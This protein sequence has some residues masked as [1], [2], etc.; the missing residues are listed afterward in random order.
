MRER[1]CQYNL[2]LIILNGFYEIES[3]SQSHYENNTSVQS[4]FYQRILKFACSR[5]VLQF[6]LITSH[7]ENFHSNACRTSRGKVGKHFSINSYKS[8]LTW[9]FLMPCPLI[10]VSCKEMS[11]FNRNK[12]ILEII[13]RLWNTILS[14]HEFKLE[15]FRIPRTSFIKTAYNYVKTLS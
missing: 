10:F 8:K 13:E 9:C 2:Y 6:S 1:P 7:G 15:P 12:V 11:F 14:V 3:Y 5:L 4:F